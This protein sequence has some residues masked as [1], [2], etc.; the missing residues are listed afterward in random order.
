METVEVRKYKLKTF[1]GGG[2]LRK[3]DKWIDVD[4]VQDSQTV[5]FLRKED[6][7]EILSGH[8]DIIETVSVILKVDAIGLKRGRKNPKPKQ[9]QK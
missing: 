8:Q 5:R 6:K 9:K 1:T 4:R 2:K 7:K 3:P